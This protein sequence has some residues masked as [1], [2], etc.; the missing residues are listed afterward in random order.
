MAWFIPLIPLAIAGGQAALNEQER[1]RQSKRAA[2]SRRS[3][4]AAARV[5]A[6]PETTATP[7]GQLSETARQNRRRKAGAGRRDRFGPPTLG[8]PGL[9]GAQA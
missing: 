3:A 8:T 5:A 2:K 1:K 6:F 7:V 9:L 4:S